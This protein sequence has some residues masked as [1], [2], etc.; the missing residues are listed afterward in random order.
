MSSSS[1]WVQLYYNHE[2]TQDLELKGNPIDIGLA[3]IPNG[4]I[5]GLARRLKEND[6][7]KELDHAGLTEIS[8]FSPRTK[9]PFSQANSIRPGKK[10]VDL[11]DELENTTP[12]TS[13]DRPLIVVAP[14]PQ[15]MAAPSQSEEKKRCLADL[16]F[17]HRSSIETGTSKSSKLAKVKKLDDGSKRCFLCEASGTPT[18][19]IEASHVLQKQDIY[20]TGGE[21]A[22][23]TLDALKNWSEGFGWKRPFKIHEPMNLIWLCHTHNLAFDRH[24][25]GLS[26]G[27]LDNSVVFFSCLKEY[28]QLV[29]DANA[30]LADPAQPFYDMSYVSRR[31]IGMRICKAQIAGYFIDHGNPNAWEA[32]VALSA[33][34][35]LKPKDDSDDEEGQ[36]I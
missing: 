7:K 11:I 3:E 17:Y 32:V 10:L 34:A 29:A 26:L 35:S 13:D 1:V 30:R 15:Q 9:P 20:A 22:L 5:S 21:E 2:E 14:A 18:N 19:K 31:A 12:P 4:N 33:A 23:L 36:E 24:E 8:V 6:M 28:A 16:L 27:G 25:F